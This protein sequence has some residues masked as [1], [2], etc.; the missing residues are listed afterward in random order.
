MSWPFP[1]KDK[2]LKPWTAKQIKQYEKLKRQ[3]M[4]EAPL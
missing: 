3:Q 4:P 1:T 2:P